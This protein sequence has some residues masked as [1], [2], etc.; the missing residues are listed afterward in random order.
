MKVGITGHQRLDDPTDWKWVEQELNI[1]LEEL[2][3]PVVG[4]TSLAI[5]A[6]QLF[7]RAVLNHGGVLEV[8]VPFEGYERIFEDEAAKREY[9]RLLRSA[10]RVEVLKR[11]GTDEEAYFAAGRLLADRSDIV[12]A[13]WNGKPAKGLGGT[14]DIVGYARAHGKNVVHLNPTDHITIGN[15]T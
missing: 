12:I 7:A 2:A 4:I 5:G 11:S 10:R 15:T 1:V 3:A 14:A 6:D 8:I 9:D 13:V